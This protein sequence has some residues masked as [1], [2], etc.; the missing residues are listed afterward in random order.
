MRV[1][2]EHD[3]LPGPSRGRTPSAWTSV[4]ARTSILLAIT[5]AAFAAI[6]LVVRQSQNAQIDLLLRERVAETE[7][8]LNRIL[9]LRASGASVHADDYT[10][11]DEFVSFTRRPDARWGRVYL[12][13]NIQTFGLNAAWVLDRKFK[14]I[15]ASNPNRDPALTG[16]PVP[17]ERLEAALRAQPI[18]HFFAETS[19]G[20]LEIWTSSIQPSDDPNRATPPSGYYVVGRIWTTERL[21][22][23]S[24]LMGGTATLEPAGAERVGSRASAETGRIRIVAPLADL[25]GAQASLLAYETTFPVVPHVHEALTLSLIVMLSA[26]LVSFLAV[27]AALARWVGHPLATIAA[28][29]RDENPS[30]LDRTTRRHDELGHLARLVREFFAQRRSLIEARESAEKAAVAKQEFL[31]SI[32]HELRTP[33]H[34]VLSYARFGSGEAMNAERAELLEYFQQIDRSGTSLLALLDELLDLA[35]FES[36]RMR[37]EFAEADLVA[38]ARDVAHEFATL[39]EERAITLTLAFSEDLPPIVLDHARV[40]QVLRNLLS[41]A[42]KFT[43][44]G[45]DVRASAERSGTVVRVAVED[46]GRGIP[47]GELE[48]VFG[49]FAQSSTNRPNTGGS[50]LGLALCR[51]VVDAHEGRIWAESRVPSGTRIVFELPVTGPRAEREAA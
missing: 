14:V 18:R 41:N 13:E 9:D 23:L 26:G 17:L 30:L 5:M 15:Y 1:P 16:V 6:F 3:T 42:A 10:R 27:A 45:G 33:M 35:K 4:G 43:P 47:S 44:K 24:G 25:Q 38:I 21:R 12:D 28:S 50:G 48:L 31:A 22:E 32:S 8:G 40:R 49:K 2:S 19:R 34:G 29:L 36:G 39:Y 20:L 51:E 7:R 37:L 11:W 46:S